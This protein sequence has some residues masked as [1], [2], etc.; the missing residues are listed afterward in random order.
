MLAKPIQDQVFN[1]VQEIGK[2]KKYDFIF[3]K[4]DVSMLYWNN[5]H[6]L[7][8]LIL[9]VINKKE[10]AEDRNK[11]MAEL[12]KEITILKWLMKRL[13]VK[14]KLNKRVSKE[15]KNVKTA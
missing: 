11:S 12:L 13:N 15:H 6:N 10:S 1:A 5:Q 2:L 9:R 7:S 8:R 4:S 3:E 14:L